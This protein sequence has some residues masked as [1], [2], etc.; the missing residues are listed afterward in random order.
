MEYNLDKFELERAYNLEILD[1][2]GKEIHFS[3]NLVDGSF[4]LR[5]VC[6]HMGG[7]CT[8]E[9]GIY[10]SKSGERIYFHRCDKCMYSVRI[11]EEYYRR[12]EN[13]HNSGGY[14]ID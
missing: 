5:K 8:H 1:N 14:Y 6:H 11:S 10:H 2:I 13:I 3:S 4:L 12:A 9:F 7:E